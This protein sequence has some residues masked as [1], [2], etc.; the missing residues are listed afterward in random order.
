MAENFRLNNMNIMW[1][2]SLVGT[3]E[4]DTHGLWFV[5][6]TESKYQIRF[7]AYQ[8]RKLINLVEAIEKINK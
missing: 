7:S 2:N 6:N 3:I 4:Q 5:P 8:L 1:S